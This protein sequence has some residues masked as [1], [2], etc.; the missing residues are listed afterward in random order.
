MPKTCIAII[1][2]NM[3]KFLVISYFLASA[4]AVFACGPS[5]RPNYYVFSLFPTTQWEQP[6][7][8]EM[9]AYWEKYTGQT[10]I[11]YQVDGLVDVNLDA[12][13]ESTNIIIQTA[14]QK[15]DSHTL[16]YLKALI[17]Y[18]QISERLKPDEWDYPTKEELAS[19][20]KELRDIRNKARG[21]K[22]G[23]HYAQQYMLLEM[24]CNLALE[25]PELNK[26]LW[27]TEA[28]RTPKNVYHNMMK[29]LFAHALVQEGKINDAIKIYAELGDITSIKWIK[30][31]RRN[32]QG[33]KSEYAAD[34][35]SHA[36]VWL[37]QD[38]VN[39]AQETKDSNYDHHA[40]RYIEATGIYHEEIR[41]FIAFARQVVAEGKT[42]SP[43]MWQAAA[44][45]L[46]SMLGNDDEAQQ[47]L[48]QALQMAGTERMIDNARV[49][50]LAVM[51]KHASLQK[52]YLNSLCEELKW[53]AQKDTEARKSGDYH[54]EQMMQRFIYSE[55]APGFTALGKP[56][57]GALL[58]AFAQSKSADMEAGTTPLEQKWG[59]YWNYIDQTTSS[60]MIAFHA[61]LKAKKSTEL[62][63][64]LLSAAGT[65]LTEDEF[66]DF[67]GTKFIREANFQAAI[68]YL[69]K[70]PLSLISKQ[71]ISPYMAQRDFN[72]D[73]WM[74]HQSVRNSYEPMAVRSNQKLDFCRKVAEVEN[75][76]QTP[77]T[78]YQL[79]SLL[80][81]AGPQGDCWYLSRYWVSFADTVALYPDEAFFTK[82]AIN[83]LRKAAKS[84]NFR[85]KEKALYALAFIP[86][87]SPLIYTDYV[88]ANQR[89]VK[90]V[91]RTSPQ[92]AEMKNLLAFCNANPGK[93]SAYVSKCDVL[94]QFKTLTAPKKKTTTARRRR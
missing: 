54:Y 56:H 87:G 73:R 79:A 59:E 23:Q 46:Q 47:M 19:L 35:N 27:T 32:L 50:R 76:P 2:T 12:L 7:H 34:A 42:K 6:G 1:P 88:G 78:A 29:G 49:C 48:N 80:Y 90:K 60:E 8:S 51:C 61:Y 52:A 67:T 85:T 44:G 55:L 58:L 37:V 82:Q 21:Y 45:L 30:F 13:N 38:F 3:K 68:P 75:A 17:R 43:A 22:K 4:M 83:L 74:G 89:A 71:S 40:M 5:S 10:N 28:Y 63:Q 41:Q 62:E 18:L 9:V 91:D 26:K 70:V 14:L 86:Y 81:Q 66:N 16:H 94:K 69:E 53:L 64:W 72:K 25:Q 65:V 93:V 24:R 11:A 84:A 36:L 15:G 33:I 77:E 31:D 20:Q 57:L 39:N 92:Y